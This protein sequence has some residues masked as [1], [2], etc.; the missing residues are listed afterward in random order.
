MYL[1]WVWEAVLDFETMASRSGQVRSVTRYRD[2]V[3]DE[4][5]EI[6]L[7]YHLKVFVRDV[8]YALHHDYDARQ[9]VLTWQLD[10]ARDH[11]LRQLEG[12]FR[13]A[14]GRSPGTTLLVYESRVDTGL[15]VPEWVERHL[16]TKALRQFLDG[17]REGAE[18]GSA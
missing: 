4:V 13:T 14:P 12:S 18:V 7:A 2:T 9:H 8:H 11:D 3:D 17:I 5:R 16:R 6:G 10:P 1:C 15:L